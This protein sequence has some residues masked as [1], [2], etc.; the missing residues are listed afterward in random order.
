MKVWELLPDNW[1]EVMVRNIRKYRN[2]EIQNYEE[3][4][5]MLETCQSC[6]AF[7]FVPSGQFIYMYCVLDKCLKQY[8]HMIDNREFK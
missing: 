4:R 5:D 2:W 6:P 3:R 7:R 1:S 8:P